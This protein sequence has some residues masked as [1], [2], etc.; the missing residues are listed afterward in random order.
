[1]S[2]TGGARRTSGPSGRVAVVLV[3]V[4]LGVVAAYRLGAF[5]SG[6]GVLPAGV[7]PAGVPPAGVI[8]FGEGYDPTSH[9]LMRSFE[10][11]RS[12]DPVMIVGHLSRPAEPGVAIQFAIDGDT[13]DRVIL[14]VTNGSEFVA[15]EPDPRV[16]GLPGRYDLVFVDA[17]G[18]TLAHGG[19]TVPR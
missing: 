9:V 16:L 11:L 8:W 1:M 10:T 13:F 19:L 3:L 7:P 17:A 5:R 6:A 2:D 12:G 4:A 14:D 18:A 15:Y